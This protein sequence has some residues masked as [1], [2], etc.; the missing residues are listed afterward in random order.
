MSRDMREEIVGA[1]TRNMKSGDLARALVNHKETAE[2]VRVAAW[3]LLDWLYVFG[4]PDTE[5]GR[6]T[7][8][9]HLNALEAALGGRA[10]R[11]AAEDAAV[12][13]TVIGG[14]TSGDLEPQ[15]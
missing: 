7:L 1:L 4:V 12:T 11:Y 6:A 13:E 5:D 15:P 3:K 9:G 2:A 8:A 10:A 14:G